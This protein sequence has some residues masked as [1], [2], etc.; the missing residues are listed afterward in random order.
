MP[1]GKEKKVCI[2]NTPKYS[3]SS[4]EESS[5]YEIDYNDLFKGLDRSKVDKIN[6]LIDALNEKY[7]LLEKQGPPDADEYAD[8]IELFIA[9]VKLLEKLVFI[10]KYIYPS[11]SYTHLDVYKRQFLCW[12]LL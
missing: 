1:Y 6:E 9:F 8:E 11:V 4:D 10:I 12:S 5:D 3:S 2:R 7:R